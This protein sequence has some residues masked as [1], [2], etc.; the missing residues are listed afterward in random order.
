MIHDT[1][2]YHV[3]RLQFVTTRLCAVPPV[4]GRQ[5]G[6]SLVTL[7]DTGE[8]LSR[9]ASRKK[10]MDMTK[11][12]STK[13]HMCRR[14]MASR[15]RGAAVAR[16]HP[17]TPFY[18][19]V[20]VGVC[21]LQHLFLFQFPFHLILHFAPFIAWLSTSIQMKTADAT[22]PLSNLTITT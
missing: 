9:R 2:L 21:V 13:T 12:E 7:E 19:V 11:V 20:F 8:Q 18:I 17:C 1:I 22:L 14:Q 6:Y 5:C 10:G 4:Q 16:T 3:Q 15:G